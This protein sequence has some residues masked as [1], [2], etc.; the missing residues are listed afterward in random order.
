MMNWFGNEVFWDAA[1]LAMIQP[2]APQ[3]SQLHSSLVLSV[4]PFAR[5]LQRTLIWNT[6]ANVRMGM[7]GYKYR[8]RNNTDQNVR[9]PAII[10]A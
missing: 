1:F 7:D 2:A 8:H 9:V 10:A 5:Q 4:T 3:S 6:H